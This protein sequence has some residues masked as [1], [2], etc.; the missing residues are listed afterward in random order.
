MS[1]T[2]LAAMLAAFFVVWLLTPTAWAE[3][4]QTDAGITCERDEWVE[5]RDRSRALRLICGE[6][7]RGG[8][9]SRLSALCDE[10]DGAS[11]VWVQ[12]AKTRVAQAAARKAQ[13]QANV[14]RARAS[15]RAAER[16]KAR[17]RVEDLSGRVGVLERR[18]RR[19]V[20]WAVGAG[21]LIVG[22]AAGYA[23]GAIAVP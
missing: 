17:R 15:E 8:W 7:D 1:S 20:P 9:P 22:G 4:E 13:R 5:L 11:Q 18:P 16:D 14:A 10:V 3:C 23:V 21:A 6:V 12:A 19:W 2:R